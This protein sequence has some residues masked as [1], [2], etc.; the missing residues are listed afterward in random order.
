MVRDWWVKVHA[1]LRH[2]PVA[3]IVVIL[4]AL[5]AGA[6]VVLSV[7][8]ISY[9]SPGPA[10]ATAGLAIVILIVGLAIS[11][12][13]AQNR[14]LSA[15]LARL[16]GEEIIPR[17]LP[18]V[19]GLEVL[20]NRWRE[21]KPELDD[22]DRAKMYDQLL[23]A[24]QIFNRRGAQKI[25][26]IKAFP[27]SK[28]EGGA[29]LVRPE[30][31]EAQVLKF[32]RIENLRRERQRFESCVHG[33]LLT[34]APGRPVDYWP[35]PSSWD[36]EADGRRGAVVYNLAQIDVGSE[37]QTFGQYYAQ[38]DTAC[39]EQA[40]NQILKV[41]APN[42][43]GV[44]IRHY[45]HSECPRTS[46]SPDEQGLYHEYRRLYEKL[47]TLEQCWLALRVQMG[48]FLVDDADDDS[49]LYLRDEY[50]LLQVRLRH[51][52]RWVRAVFADAGTFTQYYEDLENIRRDSIVH[53]DFHAGNILIERDDLAQR[54]WLIDFP[55]THVGPTVQD[56]ARLEADIKFGL[57]PS[58][59]FSIAD[60]YRFEQALLPHSAQ[61][62]PPIAA[63]QP[64]AQAIPTEPQLLKA[65]QAVCLLRDCVRHE[66]Y[67]RGNDMRPYY[68]AL[69]HA[70]LP[71]LYYRDRSP[72]QKLYAF[73]SAALLCERL[74]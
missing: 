6:T 64:D 47:N 63:L 37:I 52:I 68:L 45:Q 61:Q 33:R 21:L 12:L 23:I 35:P 15:E 40:L 38:Q 72:Q 46:E 3:L 57:L 55:H 20:V 10:I 59:G 2:N 18:R 42:W 9:T 32:E 14:K 7:R 34:H 13:Q 1:F 41:M 60:L 67:L 53:G 28:L 29:F 19:L 26:F 30:N 48:Q 36:H 31:M 11:D 27:G 58:D 62:P 50:S 39:V 24:Q 56:I 8:E 43:W 69:L 73:I 22:N 49:F 74:S 44:H 17:R 25:T 16:Q 54:I 5:L 66:H 70:T 71:I 65:W 51:P 4:T